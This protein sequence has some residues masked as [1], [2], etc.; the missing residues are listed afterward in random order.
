MNYNSGTK[1]PA[2]TRYDNLDNKYE[3]LLLFS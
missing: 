2:G 1:N 3:R